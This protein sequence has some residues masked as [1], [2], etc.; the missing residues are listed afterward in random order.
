MLA[1]I[2]SDLLEA[3]LAGAW[4]SIMATMIMALLFG[5]VRELNACASCS[6]G[7]AIAGKVPADFELLERLS[8]CG[9]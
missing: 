5:M 9:N 1:F 6:S 2:C 4:L 8:R 3:S 7:D